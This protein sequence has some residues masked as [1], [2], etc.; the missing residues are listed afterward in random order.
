M[1]IGN[2]LDINQEFV[3]AGVTFTNAA[4]QSGSCGG[5]DLLF[6]QHN[7]STSSV[8]SPFMRFAPVPF[9]Y[10]LGGSTLIAKGFHGLWIETVITA[11]DSAT[12]SHALSIMSSYVTILNGS[13]AYNSGTT[14]CPAAR[15][16]RLPHARHSDERADVASWDSTGH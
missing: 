16:P 4:G 8:A 1:D 15:R 3:P 13:Y 12:L 7:T 9:N 11:Q 10:S 5:S 14:G 6:M 2:P